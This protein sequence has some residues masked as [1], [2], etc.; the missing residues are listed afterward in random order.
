MSIA[1]EITALQTNLTAANNAVTTKG[2]TASTTGLSG[3]ATAIGTIPTGGAD[4]GSVEWVTS[5]TTSV[6][7][8]GFYGSSTGNFGINAYTTINNWV[9]SVGFANYGVY[10]IEI[11]YDTSTSTWSYKDPATGTK[12]NVVLA[13]IGLYESGLEPGAHILI[14]VSATPDLAT[15]H[16]A[17]FTAASD[18]NALC[19]DNTKTAYTLADGTSIPHGKVLSA[20]VGTD[21]TGNIGNY[22]LYDEPTLADIV[23]ASTSISAIGDYFLANCAGFDSHI[24]IPTGVVSIGNHFL[25]DCGMFN[26]TIDIPAT[27]TSLGTYFINNCVSYAQLPV[28]PTGV[29]KVPDNYMNGLVNYK[30]TINAG[31]STA[32]ITIPNHITE[33]GDDFMADCFGNITLIYF[34]TNLTKI[35]EG[36]LANFAGF[37]NTINIGSMNS[38]TSIGAGFLYNCERFRSNVNVGTKSTDIIQLP[39]AGSK[40]GSGNHDYFLSAKVNNVQQYTTG[41]GIQG[42]NAATWKAFLPNITDG[43]TSGVT[44]RKLN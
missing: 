12:T 5:V 17:A 35:G 1:S 20:R 4:Y 38:L 19:Y 29:T 27:V 44:W 25:E 24:V 33:I 41:V 23:L 30:P 40:Y 2:G 26:N 39:K 32:W 11:D 13:D 14:F 8:V 43:G 36:F 34:P 31:S 7:K 42:T 15:L 10:V 22:F 16:S 3:L 21:F 28:F 6:A 18:V 9:A 37:S